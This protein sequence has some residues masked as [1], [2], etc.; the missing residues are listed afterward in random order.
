T[1]D[2]LLHGFDGYMDFA[3]PHDELS[4]LTCVGRSKDPDVLNHG[5][6]DICGGFSM[7]LIDSIDSLAVIGDRERFETGVRNVIAV[8]DFDQDSKVQVFEVSIRVL[9]GLLSAHQLASGEIALL[10]MR[11]DWYSGELLDLAIDLGSRL[12]HAFDTPTGLPRPRVNLQSG[13]AQFA[14]SETNETCAAGA[15]SLILEFALLS[16]LS[17]IPAFEAAARKAFQ[18]V[19][20]RRLDLGL[21]GSA[22]DSQTGQW[23][24]SYTSVGA[25]VDSFY[26]YALKA[27]ILLGDDYYLDVWQISSQAIQDHI[28]DDSGFLLR[29]VHVQ[30]GFPLAGHVDSLSAFYPG[31]LVLAG[32]LEQAVKLHFTYAALWKRYRAIPERYDYV[33]KAI[34]LPFYP[35]RPEFVESTYLL[36]RATK[37]PYYLDLGRQIL[38]DLKALKTEC[39]FAGLGDVT[40][41][42]LE[43]RMESF[44]LSET[45]KYL[46]LLFDDRNPLHGNRMRDPW[47]LST[48]GHMLS[49]P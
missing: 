49:M 4:P 40:T 41:G 39:G 28:V 13:T 33:N 26:E 22:I 8:V 27:W 9:G 45:L 20:S 7:T 16:R 46:F 42:R 34:S 19:W 18:A 32:E 25:S 17:G 44:M 31:L 36:Y 12:L 35:L 1:R 37:D 30:N 6:N 38:H 2:L 29:T 48:E 14:P 24:N 10:D 43:N 23:L 47:V 21:V 11:L 15:G 5:I 3:F